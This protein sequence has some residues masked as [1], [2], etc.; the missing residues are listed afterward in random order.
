M[1]R[2]FRK[3]TQKVTFNVKIR[4]ERKKVRNSLGKKKY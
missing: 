2:N 3:K 1:C 4:W